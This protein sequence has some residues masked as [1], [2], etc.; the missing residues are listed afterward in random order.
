MSW[1]D[2]FQ[3]PQF[4]QHVLNPAL[5]INSARRL[6]EAAEHLTEDIQQFWQSLDE[7]GP[8]S[9]SVMVGSEY[10]NIFMMLYGFSVEN[11]CKAYLVTQLNETDRRQVERGQL[12]HRLK[13]HNLRYLVEQ[14]IRLELGSDE[15][16]LLQRLEAAVLW[17]GRYP[18]STGLNPNGQREI[19]KQLHSMPQGIRGDD[20]PR[21]REIVDR[22]KTHVTNMLRL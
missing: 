21:T 1:L 19:K 18:V 10:Q 3:K 22:I 6:M 8:V 11:L 4:A 5:W 9:I 17:A 20:V 12:P 13:S 15:T 14:E 16:E 2:E 7:E